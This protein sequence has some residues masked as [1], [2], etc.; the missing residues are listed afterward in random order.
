MGFIELATVAGASLGLAG[1]FKENKAT[2]SKSSVALSV[3]HSHCMSDPMIP[4]V[5]RAVLYNKVALFQACADEHL[6]PVGV[7]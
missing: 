2:R 1:I 5:V 4:Y 6:P 3:C 7:C